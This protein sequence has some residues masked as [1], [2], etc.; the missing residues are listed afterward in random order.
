M[1]HSQNYL[2]DT[3]WN[4]GYIFH[5]IITTMNSAIMIDKVFEK[6]LDVI[7]KIKKIAKILNNTQL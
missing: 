6:N 3:V 2:E 4:I 1:L 7:I 5:L